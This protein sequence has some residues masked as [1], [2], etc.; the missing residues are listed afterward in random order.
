[1]LSGTNSMVGDN[2]SW[3]P[4]CKLTTTSTTS[5]TKLRITFLYYKPTEINISICGLKMIY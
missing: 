3:T 2:A 5:V 4:C 1:M